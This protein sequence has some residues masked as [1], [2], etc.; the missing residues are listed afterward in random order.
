MLFLNDYFK[1]ALVQQEFTRNPTSSTTAITLRKT[2]SIPMDSIISLKTFIRKR[3][4][5][6]ASHLVN[7]QYH[8]IA[9]I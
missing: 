1:T 4:L 9:T 3:K 7:F 2:K 5:L 8:L 6:I